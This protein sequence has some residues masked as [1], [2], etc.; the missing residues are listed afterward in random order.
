MVK[1][2][3]YNTYLHHKHF[4]SKKSVWLLSSGIIFFTSALIVQ[5][6]AYGYIDHRVVGTP[7]GD[8]LLDNLPAL[9]VDFF[10]IQGALILSL[11]IW[12]LLLYYPE[13]VSF[14]LKAMGVF[15]IV[16]S[17]FITLTHL[18]VNLHQI[19]LDTSSIGFSIYDFLYNAK[20]DF[21]FSGHVG[22]TFLF[23]L[24]F[25][26]KVFWRNFFLISSFVLGV[27]MVLGHMHYS[28]DVFAAPFMTYSIFVMAKFFFKT[29][30]A[31]IKDFS[32]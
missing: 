26:K 18:G 30:V 5:H 19:D 13:Y 21:F 8:L 20:N 28:I 17:F 14:S 6:F 23:A 10:I 24:I 25:Q 7:V 27:S 29:D 2:F 1:S 11:V 9:D 31:L 32:H 16:R 12:I 3:L 4:W 15:L 22:A